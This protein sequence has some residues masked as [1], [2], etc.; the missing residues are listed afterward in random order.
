MQSTKI[1]YYHFRNIVSS[2]CYITRNACKT[3]AHDFIT[4][5][6]TRTTLSNMEFHVP[7]LQRVQNGAA[8]VVFCSGRR[9]HITHVLILHPLTSGHIQETLL[10]ATTV[11]LHRCKQ[12][13]SV[14]T[15]MRY[16][17][18]HFDSL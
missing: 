1:C 17:L 3:L 8:R 13:L 11:Q 16:I 2:R 12:Y 18:S 10:S 15:I 5:R 4:S 6:L 14:R 9:Q 7:R